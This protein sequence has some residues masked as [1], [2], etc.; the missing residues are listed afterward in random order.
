[1]KRDI[2]L[3]VVGATGLVGRTM[4]RVL[5][6]REIPI[7]HLSLFASARSKGHLL[8]FQGRE[9]EI[10]ELGDGSLKVD[11]A[12]FALRKSL[13]SEW[14]PRF[15]EAGTVVIDNSSYFRM[16]ADVPLVVPEANANELRHHQG[17]I[18]NPNCT[19]AIACVALAPLHKAFHLSR[20]VIS[21]YQSVSGTGQKALEELDGQIANPDLPPS[22]YPHSIAFN[23][24][25]Q[26]GDF[27]AEGFCFEERKIAEEIPKIL[28]APG[29]LVHVTTVRVPVRVGHSVSIFAEFEKEISL[30]EA[31]EHLRNAQG[32][33]IMGGQDYVTPLDCAGRDEVF[34]GRL[35]WNPRQPKALQLWVVGDNLR[36][37]AATNAVQI[38]ERLIEE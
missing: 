26:I 8:S 30:A 33:V 17:L 1:M 25:P 18:A 7:R 12:L 13:A 35:R 29:L 16:K 28:S 15:R 36:K 4:L 9:H 32:L 3:A 14:V 19:A 38:L 6:E 31:Y 10:Q 21:T 34:V 5:E 2:S 24:F 23:L 20:L 27:D 22:V 11:Y 37:G